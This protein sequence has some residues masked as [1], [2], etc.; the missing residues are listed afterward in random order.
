MKKPLNSVSSVYNSF[1]KREKD[2]SRTHLLLIS[3]ME[4]NVLDPIISLKMTILGIVQT[5]QS[6]DGRKKPPLAVEL[7]SCLLVC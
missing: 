5:K 6:L 7:Q 2:S 1:R 3:T 4:V